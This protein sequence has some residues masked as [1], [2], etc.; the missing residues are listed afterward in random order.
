MLD[1]GVH[2]VIGLLLAMDRNVLF[3]INAM[4]VNE[5]RKVNGLF[6]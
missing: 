6:Y 4:V 2:F 1:I 3:V 5:I